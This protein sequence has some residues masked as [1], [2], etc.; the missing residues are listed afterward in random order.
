MGITS[1]RFT[2][3]VHI[4]A[5]ITIEKRDEPST[6]EYLARS[7]NTNPV[8]IRRILA[9]LGKAGLVTAQPGTSGGVRLA[10]TP[11]QIT[12]L[13][14]YRAVEDGQIFN[15][16]SREPNMRCI[17]GR[18]LE[19]VMQNVF[20]SAQTA[21]EQTLSATTIA[22]IAQEVEDVDSQCYPHLEG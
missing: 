5:L 14:A 19:P 1:S 2:L 18:S 20:Q 9:M 10:R 7:A 3:A 4:L 11:E 12:L 16:G 21:M 17:C 6:S 13:D 15:Y 22:Q 8:V